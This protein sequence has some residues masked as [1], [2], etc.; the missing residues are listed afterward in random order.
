MKRVDFEIIGKKI[1]VGTIVFLVP[2]VI[3]AGGLALIS[4]FLK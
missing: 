2:L 4:K 3:L 1:V